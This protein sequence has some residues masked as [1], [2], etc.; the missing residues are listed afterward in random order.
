MSTEMAIE[1]NSC[2]AAIRKA[3][4]RDF[5]PNSVKR[6]VYMIGSLLA[7]KTRHQL[8]TKTTRFLG[9]SG[10]AQHGKTKQAKGLTVRMIALLNIQ[11]RAKLIDTKLAPP[12][13]I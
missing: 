12:E 3:Y 6:P 11:A 1:V 13:L 7:L 2:D 8:V 9:I 5:T 4:H 10:A